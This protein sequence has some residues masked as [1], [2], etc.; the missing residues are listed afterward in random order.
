MA[1]S[2]WK[3]IREHT[4]DQLI[5]KTMPREILNALPTEAP[6]FQPNPNLG[7]GEASQSEWEYREDI[8][9]L[10]NRLY[11]AIKKIEASD[12]PN[13]DK[14]RKREIMINEFR[15]EGK[16]LVNQHINQTFKEKKEI[17]VQK[18]ADI[19]IDKKPPKIPSDAQV[20]LIQYQE[21]TIDKIA[22]TIRLN[23]LNNQYRKNYFSVAYGIKE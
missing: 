6:T 1:N 9:N 12:L 2:G 4:L 18:L 14:E 15:E 13:N 19:G 21:F 5:L 10:L 16:Q 17:A 23:L 8:L 11:R 7:E 20:A 22:D 3:M